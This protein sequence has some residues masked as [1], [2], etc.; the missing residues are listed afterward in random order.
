MQ[1]LSRRYMLVSASHWPPSSDIGLE[2]PEDD[3]KGIITYGSDI[4]IEVDASNR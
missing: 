1:W 2:T 4:Y 3:P